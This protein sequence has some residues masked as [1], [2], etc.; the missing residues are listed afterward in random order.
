MKADKPK[1]AYQFLKD[2][3]GKAVTAPV[4]FP[5]LYL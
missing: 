5:I 3:V 2:N 1:K 4:Y